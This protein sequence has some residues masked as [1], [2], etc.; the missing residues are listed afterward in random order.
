MDFSFQEKFCKE[1]AWI[2]D[3][4]LRKNNYLFFFFCQLRLSL[5]AHNRKEKKTTVTYL[6]ESSYF[7]LYKKNSGP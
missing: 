5:P 4:F 6:D 3:L 7:F 2:L 1:I